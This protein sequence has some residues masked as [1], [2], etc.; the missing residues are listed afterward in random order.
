MKKAIQQLANILNGYRD[1]LRSRSAELQGKFYWEL[2][3]REQYP[4]FH[5]P[6]IVFYYKPPIMAFYD[7]SGAYVINGFVHSIPTSD[8]SLLAIL[9]SKLFWWY[10]KLSKL[11]FTKTNMR[12]A[13]IAERTSEQK[14][15]LSHIVQQILDAPNSPAVAALE[16]EIN[17]LV[18]DLYELTAAEIALIEEE[19]NP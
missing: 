9:N 7:P 3:T 4:E 2:W 1:K 10:K 18:Y 6:K 11:H 12:K 17:M 16:E 19:T 8:L 5:Q 14:R 15:E 13:P